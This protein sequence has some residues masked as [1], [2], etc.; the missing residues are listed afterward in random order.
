MLVISIFDGDQHLF[1]KGRA[2][3]KEPEKWALSGELRAALGS[4]GN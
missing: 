4:E 2:A 1:C 3:G